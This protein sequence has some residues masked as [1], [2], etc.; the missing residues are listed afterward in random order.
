VVL[1]AALAVLGCRWHGVKIARP[2]AG[3]WAWA[4]AAAVLVVPL[5]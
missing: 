4:A 1:L 2:G 3:P 5:L